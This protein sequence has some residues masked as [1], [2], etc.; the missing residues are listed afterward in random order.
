MLEERRVDVDEDGV[1]EGENDVSRVYRRELVGV[2]AE[3]V[4]YEVHEYIVND[5]RRIGA[6]AVHKKRPSYEGPQVKIGGFF[7][8]HVFEPSNAKQVAMFVARVPPYVLFGR[9]KAQ[10]QVELEKC[11]MYMFDGVSIARVDMD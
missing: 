2:Q 10:A 8:R 7:D 9:A 3:P 1:M 11:G 4:R 5:K 6:F